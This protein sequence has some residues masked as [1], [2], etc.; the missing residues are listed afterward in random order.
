MEKLYS[1]M[2]S[3]IDLNLTAIGPNRKIITDTDVKTV[4]KEIDILV[5]EL[6][7]RIIHKT[8]IHPSHTHIKPCLLD[9]TRFRK[10]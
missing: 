1:N 3:F 10:S 4:Y 5:N 8:D 7:N 2:N 9:R 6:V